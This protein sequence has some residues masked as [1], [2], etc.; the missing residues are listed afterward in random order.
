MC[1]ENGWQKYGKIIRDEKPE[2]GK[3]V[4]KGEENVWK[5]G[6]KT[7]AKIRKEPKI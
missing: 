4:E 6:G 7:A 1:T 3:R 2:Y 5:D